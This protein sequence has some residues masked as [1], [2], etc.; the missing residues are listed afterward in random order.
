MRTTITYANKTWILTKKV[1]SKMYVKNDKRQSVE[2]K[3][4]AIPY[5]ELVLKLKQ[6]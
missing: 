4:S 5:E 1:L 2:I 6:R 3:N